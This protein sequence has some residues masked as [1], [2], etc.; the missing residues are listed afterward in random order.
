[1]GFFSTLKRRYTARKFSQND[2]RIIQHIPFATF[3]RFIA[4][5]VESGWEIA[6]DF[7]ALES[8]T[9]KW[10]CKLRKGSGVLICKWRASEQGEIVGAARMV[11]GVGSE[12]AMPVFEQPQ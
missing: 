5:R 11:N 9:P 1:M 12:L 3:E 7:H 2:W 10:Q 6:S 8:D 4:N